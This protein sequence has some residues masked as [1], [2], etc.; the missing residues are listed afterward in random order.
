MHVQLLV[1]TCG[2]QLQARQALHT[3]QASLTY[4]S[5]RGACTK[6]HG[7]HAWSRCQPLQPLLAKAGSCSCMLTTAF[8]HPF[9]THVALDSMGKRRPLPPPRHLATPPHHMRR[10]MGASHLSRSVLSTIPSSV[11][12]T[13]GWVWDAGKGVSE[14]ASGWAN[15]WRFF[16]GVAKSRQRAASNTSI[17]SG[18]AAHIRSCPRVV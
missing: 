12:C 18:K 7:H 1:G 2:R 5:A 6:C 4:D 3:D 14:G 15:T 8:C 16:C 17:R 9:S 10:S 13:H 11:S